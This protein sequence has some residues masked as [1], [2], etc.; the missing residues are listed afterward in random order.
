MARTSYIK[1]KRDIAYT[2]APEMTGS[3]DVLLITDA[4]ANIP[5][6]VVEN[7]P[8]IIVAGD[9]FVKSTGFEGFKTEHE[10]EGFRILKRV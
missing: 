4:A 8:R 3:F 9:A 2:N 1:R 6:I 10:E 7:T 5:A